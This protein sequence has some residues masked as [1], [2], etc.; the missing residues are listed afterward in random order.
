MVPRKA[1]PGSAG[2]GSL[3]ARLLAAFDRLTPQELAAKGFDAAKVAR[4][5]AALRA[6]EFEV[7]P[8]AVA[9]GMVR[10]ALRKLQD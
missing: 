6:G 1:G 5:R 4:I 10:D 2:Q 9:D 7:D 8:E 3:C